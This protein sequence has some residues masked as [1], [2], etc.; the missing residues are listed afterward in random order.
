MHGGYVR[1]LMGCFPS[2][3]AIARHLEAQE[4][5]Q[6]LRDLTTLRVS[7][8]FYHRTQEIVEASLSSVPT[9][10]AAS[11]RRRGGNAHMSRS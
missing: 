11:G 8:V 2:S 5:S 9:R 10:E 4:Q 3:V 1:Q 6:M 7:H